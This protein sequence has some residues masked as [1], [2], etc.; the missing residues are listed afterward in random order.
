MVTQPP[1]RNAFLAEVSSQD[2]ELLRPHLT[3]FNLNRG[4]RLQDLG[5]V[6][7]QVVF[8]HSGLVA[9]T[10]PLSNGGSGG[11][12]LLGREGI[13]GAFG[14]AAA[15]SALCD[16]TVCIAG[17]A[18]RISASSFCHV[19]DQSPTI[20]RLVARHNAALMIQVHQTAL[21]SAEHLTEAQ[22][23]RLLLEVQDRCGSFDVPLAQVALS[24]MLGVQRT[25]VN[26]AAG[27]LEDAGLINCH[28]GHIEIVRREEL[29][30]H[31]CECYRSLKSYISS[32]FAVPV[33]AAVPAAQTEPRPPKQV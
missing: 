20:R 29:E 32:L 8:P 12:L 22:L 7:E 17:S 9:L 30:Q 24:Q 6:V 26:L 10:M 16:A 2:Y 23:S 28:R 33:A 21:C 1:D 31:A 13:L 15:T 27:K 14:A 3:R 5:A 19:L 25:T 4:E 18:A 11:A